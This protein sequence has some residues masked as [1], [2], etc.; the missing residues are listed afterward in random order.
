MKYKD[1]AK[2]QFMDK[3]AE[4]RQRIEYLEAEATNCKKA[5]EAQKVSETSYRRLFET[6]QDGI[7]L[8]D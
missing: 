6:A 8:L 1:E 3:S 5:E 7:L 4:L 2:E